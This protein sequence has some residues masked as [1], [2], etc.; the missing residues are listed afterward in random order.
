MNKGSLFSTILK[1]SINNRYMVIFVTVLFA[2]VG[3]F[4]YQK[5]IIDAVPDIT[6]VQVQVNTEAQG[7]SP[8]EVEQRITIPIE[9]FLSGLP[10]LDYT[11]SI[12]RYGLS[13]VTVAFKDGTDIYFARQ[14]IAQR[15]QES[16]DRLPIGVNTSM[17]PISTGLGEIYMYTVEND[18]NVGSHSLQ[19]LRE[20]QD[21]VIK[22]RLRTVPGVVEINSIGGASKQIIV[23]PNIEKLRAF[24][25]SLQDLALS[26]TSNNSNI[27][28]GFVENNGEQ[29][30][31]RVP[32]QVESPSEIDS[33]VVSVHQSTPIRVRDV[34]SVSIGSELRTGAATEDGREVVL[35][36]VFMLIGQNGR[37]V[38]NRVDKMI[39]D[40]SNTLPEGI[41][42]KSVYNR[43]NLVDHTI[44][45]V[46][47]NLTEGALLVV[48]I[49]FLALGNI[50]AAIITALII[51]FSMLITIFGMVQGRMSANL[52]SL[53]ALDFG[54]IVDGA[55]ILVENCIKRIGEEQARLKRSLILE[56]RLELVFS[57]SSEVRQATMFGEII[58][59]IVYVPILALQGIEGKMFHPMAITVLLALASAFVLSLTFVPAAVA[60]FI[61][62]K[63]NPHEA[64]FEKIQLSYQIILNKF[65]INTKKVLVYA[66]T[67]FIVT[68]GIFSTL[69]SEFIPSLDE[70]DIAL[71]ALR[72]PGTSLSQAISMQYQLEDEIKKVPEVS[73]MF[74]K[75]GTAEIATDPMPPSVAD[76]FVILKDRSE[77]P[78]SA[79][80]K[81]AVVSDIQEIVEKIPGNN[82]EF[83]QPIQMRFNELIAGVRSDVAIKVFGDDMS[84]LLQKADK[85]KSILDKIN[86]ANDVKVEQITGLPMIVIKPNREKIS[87]FGINIAD[88]QDVIKT[89][90]AG[91][92]VSKFYSGDRNFPIVIRLNEKERKS[93]DDIGN[94]LVPLSQDQMLNMNGLSANS[95]KLKSDPQSR[96]YITLADV[97]D[98][99]VTQGPN[100]ISRENAKRRVVVTSNIRGRDLGSFVSEAQN[101]ISKEVILPNSYWI[102]WGGQYENLIAAKNRLLIVVPIV[103]LSVFSL[104]YYTFKSIKYSLLVFSGIPFAL[105][106]GIL[107][108]WL[109]DIPFSISAAVGFIALSGVSVLNGL[110]LVTFIRNLLN[111]KFDVSA[112]VIEGAVNRLRPVLMTALVASLGFVPMAL[113][114]G[115]GSEVQRPLATVVIG[116]IISSTI[117]TLFVLPVIIAWVERRRN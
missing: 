69:G 84:I 54:L 85:I 116:G 73:H 41:K 62:G 36:T 100:Q 51:P 64:W 92:E 117:L 39:S 82:Y 75:I 4:S 2:V 50:R 112:A 70:G 81:S 97:A 114:Q 25:L 61:S 16:K 55:V 40:I 109:R 28:A 52:M 46:K 88:V 99:Y 108:L 18:S 53:G 115:T 80:P 74:A 5:L 58:I 29:L 48:V 60:I 110:V 65:I 35:G 94:L 6:N 20:I 101:R 21:W 37:D 32:S 57:A 66:I 44:D 79:K 9:M 103:L 8:F 78:N 38:A 98:I 95:S 56:E 106:G 89:A 102:S 15:L 3:L 107:G 93:I 42:I 13:Q 14:L 7:Y 72:V 31:I 43:S 26:V 11:R 90:Y 19:E 34:A 87:R 33:I 91:Q 12:S 49:L 77:W 96:P 86:G 76:G 10:N 83:S 47:K 45:T 111:T 105:S 23:S 30:L 67:F 113:S 63:I 27:G 22:P 71:H 24:E 68:L 17:G 104:I 59:A 1:F